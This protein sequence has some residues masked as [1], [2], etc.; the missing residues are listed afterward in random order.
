SLATLLK[1]IP[2]GN[3]DAVW[4][5]LRRNQNTIS[6]GL[7]K[8][9]GSKGEVYAIGIPEVRIHFGA[10]RATDTQ[11][12]NYWWCPLPIEIVPEDGET[13]QIEDVMF[14][15]YLEK[16]KQWH[17]IIQP[18]QFPAALEW[19]A[20]QYNNK[21]HVTLDQR[22]LAT[23]R[24]GPSLAAQF[25]YQLHRRDLEEGGY[26]M[27]PE[28]VSGPLTLLPL[29]S[30]VNDRD[31]INIILEDFYGLPQKTLPPEWVDQ[32]AMPGSATL[33]EE[34]NRK[35]YDVERLT[36]EI[37][38]I[39]ERFSQ[40]NTYKQLLYETGIRLEE[41]CKQVL[42]ELG[43]VILPAEAS[44]EDFI[45]EFEGQ[46]A[47]VEVKGNT[48]SISLADL[49]QL[50]RYREDYAI[51]HGAEIKGILLGNAWR[52]LPLNERIRADFPTDVVAYAMKREIA[53]VNTVALYLA[54][55]A[56]IEGRVE[57]K[58]IMHRLFGAVGATS[59]LDDSQTT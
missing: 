39:D 35:Q 2:Q 36:H 11:M 6:M 24:Y 57:S 3:D 26:S 27:L 4:K 44:Q 10:G 34:K 40:L 1:E 16:V 22:A 20:V 52:L 46:R 29:P 45:V 37:H 56:V 31:A 15:R 50:G 42:N 51:T 30:E 17:F 53:L 21:Y 25:R 9:L 48:K 32:I 47:I 23:N 14:S 49:S 58:H 54:H 55:C 19:I 7:L 18:S 13:L 59:L 12:T 38:Q 28:G 5:R 8:L 41:I 33:R 43:G